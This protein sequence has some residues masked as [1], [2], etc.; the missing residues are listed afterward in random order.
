MPR[1]HDCMDA[2]GRAAPGAVAEGR[3]GAACAPHVYFICGVPSLRTPLR[4]SAQ[5]PFFAPAF[6]ASL[7]RPGRPVRGARARRGG[8]SPDPRLLS[9]L[10]LALA[11]TRA[12]LRSALRALACKSC[13]CLPALRFPAALGR[14][15]QTLRGLPVRRAKRP[16]DACLFP[17]HPP[18]YDGLLSLRAQSKE[19]KERA[20]RTLRPACIFHMLGALARRKAPPS[21]LVGEGRGEGVLLFNSLPD[22]MRTFS[23]YRVTGT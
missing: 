16:P 3:T 13:A 7:E 19:P 2:G 20:P 9:G 18:P 17:A 6:P 8:D 22:T 15:G 23:S 12:L 11:R 21:P 4:R 14:P 1:V 5:G 10:P